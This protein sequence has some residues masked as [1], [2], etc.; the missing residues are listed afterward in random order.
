MKRAAPLLVLILLLAGLLP[1]AAATSPPP[2]KK[3]V[4]ALKATQKKLRSQL[5]GARRDTAAA[6]QVTADRDV[7]IAS[8]RSELAQ[9]TSGVS[10]PLALVAGR[11]PDGLWTAVQVLWQRFPMLPLGQLC[12]FD[13]NSATSVALGGL[14]LESYT[15]TRWTGC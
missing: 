14:S 7:T 3:Q 2:L 13:R 1:G 4:A 5:A 10:D 6:R 15:F 8:L 12:G 9:A 11:P